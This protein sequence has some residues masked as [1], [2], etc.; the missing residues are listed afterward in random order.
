M[1]IPIPLCAPVPAC[2]LIINPGGHADGNVTVSD[3]DLKDVN[4]D[5]YPDSLTRGAGDA[6]IDVRLNS[7]GKTGLLR[8]VTN[9]LG[10]SYTLDYTRA[11][12]TTDHPGRCGR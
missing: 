11:G 9:P 1:S 10:G 3:V 6:T 2:Y 5:G 4:G 7:H 12:N 8:Q